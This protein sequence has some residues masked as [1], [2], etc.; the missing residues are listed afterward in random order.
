[1]SISE[2]TAERYTLADP[3]VRLMLQVREDDA[4]AFEELM[5]RYQNRLMSLLSHLVGHRDL[6]EDLTQ[7]VFL[8]VYRARKRYVPG[9]KFS[10]WL[11]TIAGNVASNALR[12][13]ARRREVNLPPRVSDSAPQSMEAAALAASALMPTRQL[14]KAE[15]RGAVQQA[16]TALND[17]QRMAVL[18]AKFEHFSYADIGAIMDMSPQAVKSLLSRARCNLRQALQPYL[19][20]GAPVNGADAQTVAD[21]QQSVSE[22]M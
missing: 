9:A 4:Q 22:S 3:D 15:L 6:A 17:R 14:D 12:S 5:L 8:R 21:S 18:L 19:E 11:F 20:R 10:T 13:K 16:L 2:S 1:M 7:E